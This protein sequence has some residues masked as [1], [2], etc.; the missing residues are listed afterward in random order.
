M[1]L[2]DHLLLADLGGDH[3]DRGLA[4][5]TPKSRASM[6][7]WKSAPVSSS[8]LVGMHPTCRQVP[9]TLS[10]SIIAMFKPADAPYRAAA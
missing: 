6:I 8:S 3:V 2:I 5:R 4:G 9:P 10:F 1:E 7:D